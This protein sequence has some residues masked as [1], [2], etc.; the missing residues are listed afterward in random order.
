MD[1]LK[2]A[3]ELILPPGDFEEVD[4]QPTLQRAFI[5]THNLLIGYVS[6]T[7][8]LCAPV[9]LTYQK[10]CL[11][12]GFSG[13]APVLYRLSFRF[14]AGDYVHRSFP[15]CTNDRFH[16]IGMASEEF[17]AIFREKSRDTKIDLMFH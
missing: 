4:P 16:H 14:W 12:A 2:R 1:Y 9:Y 7:S 11:P 6:I 15:G 13:A 5:Y 3:F 8:I 17:L 10:R